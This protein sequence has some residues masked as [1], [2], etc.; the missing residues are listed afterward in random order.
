MH[1][2]SFEFEEWEYLIDFQNTFHYPGFNQEQS[3][4]I[5]EMEKFLE[6]HK[7]KFDVMLT[8]HLKKFINYND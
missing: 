7:S 4:S 2:N 1:E 3:I 5:P 6:R 8:E